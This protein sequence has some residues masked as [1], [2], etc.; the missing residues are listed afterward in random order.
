MDSS[1]SSSIDTPARRHLSTISRCQP[2]SSPSN[3]SRTACGDRRADAL[4]GGQLPRRTP[5]S[6]ASIEPNSV[7]SARAAVGP[8]WRIDRPTSTRHSGTCLAAV[9]V[10]QQPLAVGREHPAVDGASASVFFG[11]RA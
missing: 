7:A 6:I 4:G 5:T 2:D 9:E 3:H 11:A 1:R 10:G 8:T